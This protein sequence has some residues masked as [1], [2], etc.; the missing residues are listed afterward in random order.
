MMEIGIVTVKESHMF[1]VNF[2]WL[3]LG[4]MLMVVGVAFEASAYVLG[5]GFGFRSTA[6]PASGFSWLPLLPL[7]VLAAAHA[8]WCLATKRRKD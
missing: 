4:L 8:L 2:W 6:A 5:L 7:P 1:A 3:W